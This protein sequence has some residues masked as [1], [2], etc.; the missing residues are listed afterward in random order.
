MIRIITEKLFYNNK[1]CSILVDVMMAS[2]P[3]EKDIISV[4][5][6][7]IDLVDKIESHL[8]RLKPGDKLKPGELFLLASTLMRLREKI[9]EARMRVFEHCTCK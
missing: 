9:V 5:E 1:T 7:A 4:L 2:E 6:E 3:P 8:G